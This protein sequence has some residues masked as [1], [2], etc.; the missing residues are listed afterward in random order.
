MELPL[1]ANLLQRLTA[2]PGAIAPVPVLLGSNSNEGS[3]FVSTCRTCQDY[4]SMTASA[5][6][7]VR[8]TERNFTTVQ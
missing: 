2:R 8:W 5:N 4:F 3:G 1:D 7:Y 6:R